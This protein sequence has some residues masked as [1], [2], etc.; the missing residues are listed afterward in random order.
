[1]SIISG[2]GKNI[3]TLAART[4]GLAALGITCYDAHVLGKLE[5]DT[6]S[7]SH[8]ANRLTTAAYNSAFLDQPSVTMSKIKKGILNFQIDNNLF[9]PFEAAIGYFKG[10]GAYCVNNFIPATLGL[11]ALFGGGKKLPKLSAL[12]LVI[13][14]GYKI[15]QEGFGLGRP[16]RLN[17]PYK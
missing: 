15:I 7:Q 12:G 13:Y 6:Y 16:H 2:I 11:C 4:T 8:E 14:G 1:M 17:P 5:A 3:G 9:M 10:F